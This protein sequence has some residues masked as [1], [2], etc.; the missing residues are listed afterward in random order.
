MSITEFA[1][2]YQ[3]P[4]SVVYNASFRVPYEDRREYDGDY[5]HDAL[6]AA[7]TEELTNR[8]AF[9]QEKIDRNNTYLKALSEGCGGSG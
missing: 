4:T 3:I 7:T 6:L 5:P 9:H 2:N 1:R 8:N